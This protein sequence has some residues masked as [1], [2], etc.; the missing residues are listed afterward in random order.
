MLVL[1]P[2]YACQPDAATEAEAAFQK[3]LDD[4]CIDCFGAPAEEGG[5]TVWG[6]GMSD[7]EKIVAA[8]DWIA[9]N[10]TYDP[11]VRNGGTSLNGKTY[12]AF[13]YDPAV[14]T[15]YGV[16]ANRK[17]VCQGY[18][19]ALSALLDRA[20]VD[21][22]FVSSDP[23]DHAWNLVQ[24]NGVW[25]HV[26]VTWDDPGENFSTCSGSVMR[27]NLLLSDADIKE[28]GHIPNG[29]NSDE[30]PWSVEHDLQAEDT[31]VELPPVLV[32]GRMPVFRYDGKIYLPSGKTLY[33]F[34]PGSS[35]DIDAQS[36]E[37][38]ALNIANGGAAIT[39]DGDT[40]YMITGPVNVFFEKDAEAGAPG[41]G[42][43]FVYRI[44][45]KED[46]PS[47]ERVAA[48]D[49]DSLSLTEWVSDKE[50]NIRSSF[51]C[52]LYGIACRSGEL[53]TDSDYEL[54]KLR[55]EAHQ[56][57]DKGFRLYY[58]EDLTP[59]AIA[60][61][62]FDLYIG[63]G[64]SVWVYMA[65]Y[66]A[67]GQMLRLEALDMGERGICCFGSGYE[68]PSGTA[69]VKLFAV[70]ADEGFEGVPLAETIQR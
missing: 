62:R 7:L 5:K 47:A 67:N 19:L 8:H 42:T 36:A 15:A 16:F 52:G 50:G 25:Y 37:A 43:Q 2:E 22:R 26:D 20:W 64:V 3:A 65:F 39:L 34:V 11:Y 29:W 63:E 27:Y 14:Y 31:S 40:L 21:S 28:T 23:L 4:A 18:A 69:S 13:A 56:D 45:L 66:N 55:K 1:T 35:F 32:N 30:S 48:V 46:E 12:K 51:R 9:G 24:L 38:S 61:G 68:P 70:E 53:Y 57:G 33:S 49:N 58:P 60:D 10:C 44:S 17:A 59:D 41:V 54:V 6:N